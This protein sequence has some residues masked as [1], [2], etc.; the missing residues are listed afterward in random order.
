M[1]SEEISCI[2]EIEAKLKGF[3]QAMI[4]KRIKGKYNTY[5]SEAMKLKLLSQYHSMKLKLKR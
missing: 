2:K 5:Q 1:G 4:Y 3:A